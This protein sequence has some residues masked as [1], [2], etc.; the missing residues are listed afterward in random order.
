MVNQINKNNI[1][2]R[3]VQHIKNNIYEVSFTTDSFQEQQYVFATV[4]SNKLI[5]PLQRT[6]LR[7][8]I[9]EELYCK[10]NFAK[11]EFPVWITYKK[12]G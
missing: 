12:S 9:E 1:K 5:S 7:K 3:N 10:N 11:N 6:Q 4:Q 8:H 2:G